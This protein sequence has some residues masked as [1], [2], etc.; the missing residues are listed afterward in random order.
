LKVSQSTLSLF[1][2]KKT[3]ESFAKHPLPFFK[4]QKIESFIKHHRLKVPPLS[5][6]SKGRRLKV[7]L[8]KLSIRGILFSI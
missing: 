6:F 4:K 1:S 8:A 7:L 5:L 2:K 3:I